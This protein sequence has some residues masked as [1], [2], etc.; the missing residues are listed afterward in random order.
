MGLLAIYRAPRSEMKSKHIHLG[1]LS[2]RRSDSTSRAASNLGAPTSPIS[3]CAVVTSYLMDWDRHVLAWRLS[4]DAA[5]SAAEALLMKLTR[6]MASSEF[7]IPKQGQPCS[8]AFTGRLQ[9]WTFLHAPLHG[10]IFTE[11]LWRSLRAVYLH[12]LADRLSM[13][14]SSTTSGSASTT[15][16]RPHSALDGNPQLRGLP[17]QPVLDM[18]GQAAMRFAHTL[19]LQQRQEDLSLGDSGGMSDR[20]LH[21]Q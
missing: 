5:F 20:G 11:R 14:G 17:Q 19:P 13:S 8:F 21:L 2:A 1:L 10:N 4:K 16:R 18:I 15:P 12:D 7:S 3:R 9:I 6:H